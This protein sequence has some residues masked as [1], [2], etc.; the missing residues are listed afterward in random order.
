MT[1][2]LPE[3][4]KRW[5]A[6]HARFSNVL[7]RTDVDS[8]WI[9]VE[10]PAEKTLDANFE[11]FIADYINIPEEE[12]NGW[13]PIET[14]PKDGALVLLFE[15]ISGGSISTGYWGYL[16]I[17]SIVDKK[18]G[19]CADGYVGDYQTFDKPTHWMPL[20]KPPVDNNK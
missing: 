7:T 5:V 2:K 15:D 9:P 17:H 19:W 16:G 13:Q 14:A 8:D 11:S 12:Q 6:K 3:V 4:G 18:E 10:Y 1:D 20:P